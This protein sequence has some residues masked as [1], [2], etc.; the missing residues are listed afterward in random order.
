MRRV[1]GLAALMITVLPAT[2]MAQL[3]TYYHTG[4]WD[5]FSGKNSQG[6]AV[7]G[8]GY[9][10]PADNRRLS[11]RFE[12]G[13]TETIFSASKP[14]W[15][16]PDNTR[17]TVVMQVGLTTPWTQPATGS[18]HTIEWALDRAGIQSFDR[19]FRSASSMTVTFPD[20]NEPPWTVSLAGSTAISDTLGRC[21][22]DLTRQVQA[23]QPPPNAPP[24][25]SGAT[26][27][28]GPSVPPAL[29]R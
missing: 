22:R 15:S 6:R 21:V 20:G 13:G 12:I 17:I 4:A 19:Q 3:Q 10:N 16:I 26:Q 27:P 24:V 1:C 29:A 5:A 2:G 8:M 23:A 14:N 18:G 9:T 25:G 11:L 7:C 28:F